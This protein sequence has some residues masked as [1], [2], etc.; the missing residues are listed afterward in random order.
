[1]P[2]PYL[3]NLSKCKSVAEEIMAFIPASPR[4]RAIF[5][6]RVI[7]PCLN[8][9]V[10]DAVVLGISDE[11]VRQ[12]E[13][14]LS[15]N[16]VNQ[17]LGAKLVYIPQTIV[18]FSKVGSPF[19]W[20]AWETEIA[21]MDGK[22]LGSFPTE[23]A[24]LNESFV[25][26]R[27]VYILRSFMNNGGKNTEMLGIPP[28]LKTI[29][30]EART[31]DLPH[32]FDSSPVS[33]DARRE[34]VR[35]VNDSGAV[36]INA[37]MNVINSDA[38]GVQ[39][40]MTAYGYADLGSGWFSFPSLDRYA[41]SIFINACA[42]MSRACGEMSVDVMRDGVVR[43]AK[44]YSTD[45]PGGLVV[46]PLEVFRQLLTLIGFTVD[47]HDNVAMDNNLFEGGGL[48]KAETMFLDALRLIGP[49]LS[50]YDLA[51][52]LQERDLSV[53]SV[54][55]VL[56][57]W[58]PLLEKVKAPTPM[59]RGRAITFYK[60]RG[61]LVSG[62]DINTAVTRNFCEGSDPN[63][64]THSGGMSDYYVTA[65]RYMLLT[66]VFNG[67]KLEN[68]AGHWKVFDAQENAL[69]EV[70]VFPPSVWGAD[71]LVKSLDL[72]VGTRLRFRFN[73]NTRT[74]LVEVM[75]T[76]VAK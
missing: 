52:Y 11:R 51:E 27:M 28:D 9:R 71:D 44:R 3:V 74:V 39:Q 48:N 33:P 46:P 75:S 20:G 22:A 68:L 47:K 38:A 73:S 7:G 32:L 41:K 4:H 49:V 76:P 19:T 1:M 15:R 25:F 2:R 63:L 53:S 24:D 30:A 5:L 29:L 43:A 6:W 61:S 35:K 54:N 42:K 62:A 10:A 40:M 55:N 56:M 67:S 8:S 72:K 59:N 57:Q 65:G 23:F 66:G 17:M 18:A 16:L 21:K 45:Q 50:L 31:A 12:I 36:N 70:T 37:V 60:L 58:S 14:S 13:A 64:E 69:G 26:H 34:I